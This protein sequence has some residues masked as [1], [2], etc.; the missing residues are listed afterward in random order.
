MAKKPKKNAPADEAGDAADE[1]TDEAEG[2][3]GKLKPA[4]IGI[5]L[6]LAGVALGSKVM[7]GS[8]TPE[9][10]L[11]ATTTTTIPA[12]PVTTLDAITL[13]LADGRFLKVGI[14]IELHKDAEYPDLGGVELDEDDPTKGF[15]RELDAAIRILGGHTFDQLVSPT[16]RDQAKQVLLDE[17]RV[18]SEDAVKDLYFHVFVM[19]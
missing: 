2:K 11:G 12:G 5:V 13:N 3:S 19:Q 9:A 14:A 16:G 7:G 6:L 10:A 1:G 15:A 18:L 17:M 4:V 8:G